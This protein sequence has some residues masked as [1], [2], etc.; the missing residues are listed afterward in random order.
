[1]KTVRSFL[2]RSAR[3]LEDSQCEGK[4]EK[5][6]SATCMLTF[7]HRRIPAM[8]IC[9]PKPIDWSEAGCFPLP[10]STGGIHGNSDAWD[11]QGIQA[12]DAPPRP[13][14]IICAIK[15]FLWPQPGGR[16]LAIVPRGG[17]RPSCWVGVRPIAI[18]HFTVRFMKWNFLIAMNIK[19]QIQVKPWVRIPSSLW[20]QM[21]YIKLL[22]SE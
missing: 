6:A 12:K 18:F 3:G 21:G 22:S 2:G 13:I 11:P 20:F 16:G 8:E 19:G 17:R 10:I 7:R 4:P 15:A 9:S 1:M 14:T 5:G